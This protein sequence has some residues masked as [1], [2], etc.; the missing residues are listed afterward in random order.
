MTATTGAV[1]AWVPSALPEADTRATPGAFAAAPRLP[2]ERTAAGPPVST[3][4][5]P[6]GSTAPGPPEG[7][8]VHFPFCHAICP[9]CDFVVVAGSAARGPRARVGELL[10]AELHEL[11]LRAEGIG[12]ADAG[13]ARA[14]G[15]SPT[16]TTGAPPLG[17]VYLGGGTPSLMRPGQVDRLLGR[18]RDLLGLADDAEVTLEA[19]PGP[20]EVGDLVGF[21]AAGVTRL[22]I[23]AQSLDP[24]ELRRLGRRHSPADVAVTV[25]RAR[26]AGFASISLD[27]LTDVPGQTTG[28]WRRSLEGALELGPDHLSVY[29]LDLADPDAEGL[30]DELGDHLPASRGARAWRA[31][32]RLE[33]SEDRAAE[34][35]QLTDELATAAGMRR[36]E[37]ANLARPG[38]ESRHN[39]LYWRRR[40]V[41]AVG[42]GAHA[43]DGGRRRTW[44]AAGLDAYVAALSAGRL[45]PG[46]VDELEEAMAV[47]EAAMLGLRLVEGIEAT[48]AAHPAVAPALSWA[49]RAGLVE[50]VDGRSRLTAKGR[51]LANEVFRRLLPD[52][53]DAG[54][55]PGATGAAGAPAAHLPASA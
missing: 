24:A 47:A 22:S 7:L 23:G 11:E 34:M 38:H 15:A 54:D 45:P 39:R 13:P 50:V 30:T 12:R 55:P 29:A 1:A 2:E 31:R 8:Y 9:Y 25:R 41:L 19:N 20:R 35:E 4:P 46:G 17:S 53:P 10:E 5:G 6:P 36:Y 26:A 32:A 51:L 43:F 42:P 28:S 18:V 52:A 44:N 3:A 49:D 37:I 40:P 21:R 14:G 16:G 33:Q 27:L 48:L